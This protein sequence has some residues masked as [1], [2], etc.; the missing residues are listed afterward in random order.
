MGWR[1]ELKGTEWGGM[2]WR[3]QLKGTDGLE[4]GGELNEGNRWVGM[5]SRVE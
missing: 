1:V 5:G 4:W 2:G 3:V